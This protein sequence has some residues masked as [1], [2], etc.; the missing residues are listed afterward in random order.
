MKTPL[1]SLTGVMVLVALGFLFGP[2]S[3]AVQAQTY[4]SGWTWSSIGSAGM[5]DESVAAL[6]SFAGASVSLRSSA[7]AGT[8]AVIRYPVTFS[9]GRFV[10]YQPA[11]QYIFTSPFQE[12]RLTMFFQKNDDGAYASAILKRVRLSDGVESSVAGVNS[13]S[14]F[15]ASGVQSVE[16][17]IGCSGGCIDLTQYAYYIEAV[18]WKPAVGNDPKL[19]VIRVQQH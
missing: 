18:L 1:R 11:F 6:V 7:P 16:R 17:S 9:S 14:S 10:H 3:A 4:E 13:L 8:V 5:A 19:T 15:P 12:L 2:G